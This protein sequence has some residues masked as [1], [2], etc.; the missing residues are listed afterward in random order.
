LKIEICI[1]RGSNVAHSFTWKWNF[2]RIM[3]R[4]GVCLWFSFNCFYHYN[5]GSF[6]GI[7]LLCWNS[8]FEDDN[9]LLL[10]KIVGHGVIWDDLGWSCF[11]FA[12]WADLVLGLRNT[13]VFCFYYSSCSHRHVQIASKSIAIVSVGDVY[14]M[15]VY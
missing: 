7:F 1:L 13:P 12:I 4:W 11:R 15:F 6:L 14:G 5:W 2:G 10:W 8:K 3:R 9:V